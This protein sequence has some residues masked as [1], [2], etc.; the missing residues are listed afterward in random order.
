[1]SLE[2]FWEEYVV[3]EEI[4]TGGR[5]VTDA[6][7]RLFI[8]ATDATHPAHVN[9]EYAKTHPFGQVVAPGSLII[10]IID[11]FVVKDLVPARR[12]V[13]HYG[14]NRVRFLKPVFVGDTIHM[15]ARVESK[16]SRED[17]F[18][19]VVF[20]YDVRN[21]RG[22]TVAIVED[23]QLIEAQGSAIQAAG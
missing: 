21:H 17:G 7:I 3:G 22:Q 6:D 9:E 14:Y 13:A 19:L 2:R 18:G 8:G 11:G 5:T 15:R 20:A 16:R 23:A 1:M 10:G 12:K 4:V